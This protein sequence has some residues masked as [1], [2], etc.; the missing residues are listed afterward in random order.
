MLIEIAVTSFINFFKKKKVEN[1]G[2][3]LLEINLSKINR[4]IDRKGL[5]EVLLNKYVNYSKWIYNLK[6]WAVSEYLKERSESLMK[7]ASSR[8]R[9]KP[10]VG[11]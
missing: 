4:K 10:V 1:L 6:D 3:P 5:M 2:I 7:F 9:P 11:F 8:I